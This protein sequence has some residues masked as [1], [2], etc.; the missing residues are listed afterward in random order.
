MG[1]VPLVEENQ[2]ASQG[3]CEL[4]GKTRLHGSSMPGDDLSNLIFT[5]FMY[6]S[7]VFKIRLLLIIRHHAK[8][9]LKIE[10]RHRC[11]SSI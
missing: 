7:S 6:L 10:I 2:E 5:K 1:A 9:A 4:R 11:N 8:L 3:C